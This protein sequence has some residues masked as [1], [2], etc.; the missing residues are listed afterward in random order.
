MRP[1]VWLQIDVPADAVPGLYEGALTVRHAGGSGEIPVRLEV[2]PIRL[3]EHPVKKLA[4]YYRMRSLA[5]DP[6]RIDRDLRDIY[7]HGLRHQLP[8]IGLE[9]RFEGGKWVPSLADLEDGLDRLQRRDSREARS[10]STVV[11]R[12]WRDRWGM[13]T[14]GR[15]AMEPRWRPTRGFWKPRGS[16]RK[17][18]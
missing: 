9:Y 3:I 10:S 12:R 7:E 16:V 6:E 17:R 18:S 8:H 11:S 5:L 15:R 13:R 1:E 14:W 4:S 2:L